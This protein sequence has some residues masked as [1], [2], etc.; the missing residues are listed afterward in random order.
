VFF[1][2]IGVDYEFTPVKE[3]ENYIRWWDDLMI[4]AGLG[5]DIFATEKFF[6][7]A[8]ALYGFGFPIGESEYDSYKNTHGLLVKIGVGWMF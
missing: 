2:T 7:R 8:H 6:I 1:P 4:R 5:I 3:S